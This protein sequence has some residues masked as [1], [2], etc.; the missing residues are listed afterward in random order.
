MFIKVL[1]KEL[2]INLSFWAKPQAKSKNLHYNRI[3]TSLEDP[4]PLLRYAQDDT[5]SCMS[6]VKQEG[7]HKHT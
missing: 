7:I 3:L 2:I 5:L 4:S 1:S 6:L